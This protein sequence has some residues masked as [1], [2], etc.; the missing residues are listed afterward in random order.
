MFCWRVLALACL[1]VLTSVSAHAEA[2]RNPLSPSSREAQDA[3]PHISA[4]AVLAAEKATSETP[5]AQTAAQADKAPEAAKDK[6]PEA[7]TAPESKSD[8]ADA[9]PSEKVAEAAKPAP[10]P[11]P[12]LTAKIDLARQTMVVSEDG[13]VKYSW[14]ISSGAEEFPSPRGTFHPQ[15]LAKMWYSKKYDNAPMPNAVFIT[16]GVAIH[17][18]Q[19]VSSLGRPASHGCIRL[20]PGNA[21]TFYNLVQRH[22]LKQTRVSIFGTPKWRSPAVASR[23]QNRDQPRRRYVQRDDGDSWFPP[24]RKYR[25]SYDD[26]RY[27]QRRYRQVPSYSNYQQAPRVYYRGPGGQRF[28]YVQRPQRRYYYNNDGYG[29]GW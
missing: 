13:D 20:A 5:A 22:G 27:A 14:P 21:K 6:A 18:T 10:P 25:P 19:H 17:A 9:K 12:T 15:W 23:D 24:A 11:A 7:A 3:R 8:S 4:A 1:A 28:V 2:E 29:Y 16:G 26:Q